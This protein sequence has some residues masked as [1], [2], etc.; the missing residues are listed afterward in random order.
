[1]V[2]FSKKCSAVVVMNETQDRTLYNEDLAPVPIERRTWGV[3]NYASLW[4]AMSV[5][6]PTYMLASGL[7]AG[8]MNCGEAL[9]P[10][11]LGTQSAL[12]P[13]PPTRPPA[14]NTA[15]HSQY[16]YAHRSAC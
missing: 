1:A 7:I 14:R 4:V 10:I 16:S 6:I 12:V 15:S 5:C 11:L 13:C 8:G 2:V 9:G 3:Y